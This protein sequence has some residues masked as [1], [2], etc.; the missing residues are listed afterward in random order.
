VE[1]CVAWGRGAWGG[2]LGVYSGVGGCWGC[3]EVIPVFFWVQLDWIGLDSGWIEVWW[4]LDGVLLLSGMVFY[5]MLLY[6]CYAWLCGMG[7]SS[8]SS[9]CRC[10]GLLVCLYVVMLPCHCQ[11][12][13]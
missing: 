12:F 2:A 6:A 13:L 3:L 9:S 10:L 7:W 8:V 5:A 4:R 1:G 11:Y